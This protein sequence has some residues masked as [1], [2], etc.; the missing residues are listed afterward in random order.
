MRRRIIGIDKDATY[1]TNPAAVAAASKV[2][3][4]DDTLEEI[5]DSGDAVWCDLRQYLFSLDD[6]THCRECS[7]DNH[8]ATSNGV[9]V[10][11]EAPCPA[12]R[13]FR[14]K[15]GSA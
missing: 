11:R 6:Q 12:R 3:L 8:A 14:C 9:E 5:I 2:F 4:A 13:E 10:N 7:P 1:M 15:R